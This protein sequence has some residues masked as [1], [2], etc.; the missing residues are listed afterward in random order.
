MNIIELRDINLM[1]ENKIIF[2]NFNLNLKLG[3]KLQICGKSGNGKSTLLKIILGFQG[4]DSGDIYI[5]GKLVE[6]KGFAEARKLV[7]YVDQDVSLQASNV[8]A[9]LKNISQFKY[10]NYDGGFD[11]SLADLFEFNLDL[12]DKNVNEL[13]GGERQRLGIII[14]IMLKR[15]IFLLDEAT[16][17]LDHDLK[18]K[19]ADYFAKAPETVIAISHD[20]VW[21][22]TKAFR[23]VE[24]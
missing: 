24:W 11:N 20:E 17:A 19:V 18:I 14:A 13:T 7:S 4:I 5:N 8:K 23:R 15:Q 6:G 9:L 12:L 22:N 21:D 1:Q 16:S 2:Q 3:E 10:N